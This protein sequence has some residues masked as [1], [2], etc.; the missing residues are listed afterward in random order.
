MTNKVFSVRAKERLAIRNLTKDKF[1]EKHA[2]GTLRKAHRSGL[3]CDDHYLHERLAFEF[4]FSF[5]SIDTR[6]ECLSSHTG[7]SYPDNPAITESLWLYD[8]YVAI[9]PFND[10]FQLRYIKINNKEDRREGL[11]IT[12]VSDNPKIE[13]LPINHFVFAIIAEYDP[14]N[15]VWKDA[16]NP[17]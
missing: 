14:V 8:R 13:W 9:N 16:V 17:C 2:S 6:L 7:V 3:N 1:I 11:A 10:E 12:L 4:G 5:E 15:K